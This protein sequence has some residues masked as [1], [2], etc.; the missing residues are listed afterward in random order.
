MADI[1]SLL[2]NPAIIL[3]LVPLVKSIILEGLLR[4]AFKNSTLES[5]ERANSNDNTVV[6]VKN[7]VSDSGVRV[8]LAQYIDNAASMEKFFETCLFVAFSLAIWW[9]TE[10]KKQDYERVINIAL[11]F[12]II[13]VLIY[14]GIRLGKGKYELSRIDAT[15]SFSYFAYGL[16]LVVVVLESVAK[17]TGH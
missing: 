11:P 8:A 3:A 1:K 12:L 6:A 13:V 16:D 2:V 7:A 10:P 5:L 15:K 14:V 4:R 17:L 9:V